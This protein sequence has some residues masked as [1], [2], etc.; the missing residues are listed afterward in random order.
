MLK[1]FA[2]IGAGAG[3]GYAAVYFA[4]GTRPAPQPAAE[5][6]AAAA[7]PAEP[8]VLSEVVEVTD[9]DPLL[10]PLLDP[11][12]GQPAGLP[13]DP[14]APTAPTA[15]TKVNATPPRIPRAAD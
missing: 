2:I 6:P 4:L 7:R 5:Q 15:P 11:L 12:P 8:V 3:V 14:T 9:T 13:F 1:W 10:D